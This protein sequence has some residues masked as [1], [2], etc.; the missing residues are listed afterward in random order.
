MRIQQLIVYVFVLCLVSLLAGPATAHV[1][2]GNFPHKLK[3]PYRFNLHLTCAQVQA[4]FIDP[5]ANPILASGVGNLNHI[6]LTGVTTYDGKGQATTEQNGILHFSGPY[7]MGIPAGLPLN[8]A[9]SWT[10]TVNRHG[11]VTVMGSCTANDGS[12]TITNINYVG[13]L[14]VSKK[15]LITSVVEPEVR[16]LTVTSPAPFSASQICAGTGTELRIRKK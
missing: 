2:R 8:E 13:Q 11:G 1:E 9:C 16:T 6:S 3:G 10:Y 4:G 15:V 5:S 14:G 7:A 12:Y